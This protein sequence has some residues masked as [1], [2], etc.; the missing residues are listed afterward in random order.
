MVRGA[1]AKDS[2]IAINLDAAS[3]DGS[4]MYQFEML[5]LQQTALVAYGG[6][7]C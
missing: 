1:S 5:A 3:S 2:D 6:R 4:P 7:G